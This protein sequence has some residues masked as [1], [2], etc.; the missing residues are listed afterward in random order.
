MFS[1]IFDFLKDKDFKYKE[2]VNLNKLS[3][4]RIGGIAPLVVY[5][6]GT[7][8]LLLLIRYLQNNDFRY[9]ILG[10][11][12]NIL[13]KRDLYDEVFI[14]TC[15]MGGVELSENHLTAECGVSIPFLS[16]MT[17]ERGLSGFEALSG[18]PASCGGAVRSNAGAFGTEI[19]DILDEVM[20][21]DRVSEQIRTLGVDECDFSYRHSIFHS[22]LYVILSA[23]FRLNKTE[24]DVHGRI[25]CFRQRR[26]DTQPTSERSLGSTFKRPKGAY[27]AELIDKCSLKGTRVGGVKISEKHA[28]FIVNI[29]SGTADDYL[30]LMA[31]VS[32]TVYDRFG[33]VLEPEIEIY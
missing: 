17:A 33:V 3:A 15:D 32:R 7:Q 8:Q 26:I 2:C 23:V 25:R 9:K 18:I 10:R 30:E 14:S 11:M 16:L 24:D 27:A 20:V 5:P 6:N 28:G 1:E 29:G 4:A 19:S 12:T 31:L 22:N 21:F 13:F